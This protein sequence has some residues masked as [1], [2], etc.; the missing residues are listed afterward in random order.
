MFPLRRLAGNPLT[1]DN[2]RGLRITELVT[3]RPGQ[4]GRARQPTKDRFAGAIERESSCPKVGIRRKC[5][6]D[7]AELSA[8]SG[9]ARSRSTR[10]APDSGALAL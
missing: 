6:E 5:A 10:E 7:L 9:R 2:A 1:P 4:L 8:P 3:Q